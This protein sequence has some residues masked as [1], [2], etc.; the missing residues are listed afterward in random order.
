MGTTKF[1]AKLEP[2]KNIH[3]VPQEGIPP[4]ER[5]L[6]KNI[7]GAKGLPKRSGVFSALVEHWSI[8]F[9][10]FFRQSGDAHTVIFR[11]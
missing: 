9:D 7:Y 4:L 6:E 8:F 10:P 3:S 11:W 5:T 1:E 2:K